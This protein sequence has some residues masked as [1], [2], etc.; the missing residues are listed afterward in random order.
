MLISGPMGRQS[1]ADRS[2][3]RTGVEA[4]RDDVRQHDRD[5]DLD[6]GAR[7]V[8]SFKRIASAVTPSQMRTVPPATASLESSASI[9]S[10]RALPHRL[11][12]TRRATRQVAQEHAKPRPH[13]GGYADGHAELAAAL[14]KLSAPRQEG[15]VIRWPL[16]SWLPLISPADYSG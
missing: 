6:P 4:L 15:E 3:L 9:S 10:N 5:F 13:D 11:S 7:R 1:C 16:H 8:A 12:P 2:P 14:V